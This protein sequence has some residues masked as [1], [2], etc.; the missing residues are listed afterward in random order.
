M[1]G[2]SIGDALFTKTQQRV[3]ALLYG[4]CENSFYLNEIV[5][6]ASIGRGSVSRELA[7][8]GEAGL[9]VVSHQGNQ[10]H[11]QAN[12]ASPIFNE[13]KH[14]VQ[15]TF[16]I[17]DVVREALA[18]VLINLERAFIYGSVAKGEAH[19]ASD[20]DV[21]LVGEG[22]SYADIM[23]RL[24]SVET[25]LQRT[26]NPTLYS[27]AEFTKRVDESQSF[28]LGVMEQPKI[29]LLLNN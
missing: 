4:H 27:P 11:Y 20:V 28:I 8:L 17:A 6:I 14:I 10:N 1:S 18:P 15:K 25:R 13:L 22:L 9:L 29:N 7:K 16:G 12:K 24:E 2:V 19:A 21:M 5:R 26:V 3:L 23:Q